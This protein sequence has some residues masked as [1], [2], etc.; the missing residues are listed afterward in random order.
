MTR[1]TLRQAFSQFLIVSMLLVLPVWA[2]DNQTVSPL[3]TVAPSSANPATSRTFMLQEIPAILGRYF[4]RQ[5]SMSGGL[6]GTAVGCTSSAISSEIFTA[7]GN[8]VLATTAGTS[9]AINYSTVGCDCAN[10]G[11]DTAWVI[12]SSITGNATANFTRVTG[13]NYFVDCAASARPALPANSAWLMETT[14]LNGAITAVGD[15]RMVGHDLIRVDYPPYNA[16]CDGATAD[17]VAINLAIQGAKKAGARGNQGIVVSFPVARCL[18]DNPLILPRT[19]STPINVVHLVGSSEHWRNTRL[20]GSLAFPANRAMIEWEATTNRALYQRIANLTLTLPL[21]D[22]TMAIWYAASDPTNNTT[23]VA[24][25]WSGELSHINMEGSNEFHPR[26]IYFN[27]DV[28]YSKFDMIVG[29][30]A[31]GSAINYE[32]VMLE[33]CT[34]LNGALIGASEGCGLHISSITNFNAGVIRGGFHRP[35]KVRLHRSTVDTG[36]NNGSRTDPGWHFLNSTASS[37]RNISN[38]GRGEKP[39]VKVE[40]SENMVLE[41]IG[42]AAPN[43]VSGLG[44]GN[45][46]EFVGTSFSRVTGSHHN[47]GFPGFNAAGVRM[48]TT[49]S[50]SIGNTF[51]DILIQGTFAQE[52]TDAGADNTWRVYRVTS[53]NTSWQNRGKFAPQRGIKTLDGASPTTVTLPVAELDTSYGIIVTCDSDMGDVTYAT[54]TTTTFDIA[55]E[56]PHNGLCAW[57]L[58][59]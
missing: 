16:A 50:A 46:L 1:H 13:T 53:G 5:Y 25:R 12:A 34:S 49:D 54:K 15:M 6:H 38:E 18:I 31:Q 40:G 32:T 9:A 51:D 21:V 7:A 27:A 4:S 47:S 45:G 3:P 56:A 36:F 20:I 55:S 33:T 58:T 14:I 37:V 17:D 10:P 30:Q 43:A 2:T 44:V 19:G 35:M 59:R 48:I 11:G 42:L 24:Q 52:I 41:N 8:R 22:G 26:L 28:V 23:L 57:Q 39:Q 29:D